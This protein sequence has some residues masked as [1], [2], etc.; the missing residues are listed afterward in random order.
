[1]SVEGGPDIVTNGLVLYLDAANNRS[2]VSGSTTWFDLSRNGNT[3]SLINGPTF[4][5]INGGY[6]TFDGSNDY[7][8]IANPSTIT[9]SQVSFCVWNTVLSNTVS[10]FTVY[11]EGSGGARIFA[12]SIPWG[13]NNTV[14]FDAG[15]GTGAFAGAF[16]RINKGY[17]GSGWQY[18]VFT[19]NATA[20]TMRIYLNGNLWHSG[21]GLNAPVGTAT[22]GYIATLPSSGYTNSRISMMKFYNKELSAAEIRQNYHATKGRYGL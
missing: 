17:E 5:S 13:G 21:T 6:L 2:I 3:G 8:S 4:S 14:Y 1:M 22:T 12:V 11:L 20:G 16:D 9:G 18:W 10:T 19:K 15:N 7:C